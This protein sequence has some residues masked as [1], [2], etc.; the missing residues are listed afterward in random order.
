M[1]TSVQCISFKIFVGMFVAICDIP[2]CSLI[3]DRNWNKMLYS[4]RFLEMI[5]DVLLQKRD[6]L[7]FKT[8]ALYSLNEYMEWESSCYSHILNKLTTL[9]P[10]DKEMTLNDILF[11]KHPRNT[12]NWIPVHWH[13]NMCI[14]NW[15]W[16]FWDTVS[17]SADV[18]VWF[19]IKMS[20]LNERHEL[21]ERNQEFNR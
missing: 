17:T 21:K 12:G 5:S 11:K 4:R 20:H 7:T 6:W 13:T 18:Q 2:C 8:I 16:N 15:V 9:S 14:W 3:Q 19:W 1:I 10:K